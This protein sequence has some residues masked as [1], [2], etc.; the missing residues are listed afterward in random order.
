MNSSG[1]QFGNEA[2]VNQVPEHAQEQ[3]CYVPGPDP[4]GEFSKATNSNKYFVRGDFNLARH[5]LTVR[6]NYI[7][8]L[9]DSGPPA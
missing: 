1:Q 2:A 9:N 8:A 4:L 7:D 3:Y 6:H 5:Q